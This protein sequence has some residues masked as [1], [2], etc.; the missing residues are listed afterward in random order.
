MWRDW[1]WRVGIVLGRKN[2]AATGVVLL[3]STKT[4]GKVVRRHRIPL[5]SKNLPVQTLS[6]F[7][8]KVHSLQ[9]VA[10][11]ILGFANQNAMNDDRCGSQRTLTTPR[12]LPHPRRYRLPHRSERP[13]AT[14]I[15]TEWASQV[16]GYASCR[17]LALV[18][19][20]ILKHQHATSR[21]GDHC[22]LPRA[23][24]GRP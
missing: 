18:V 8:I 7:Q 11:K 21:L 2:T 19:S 20:K 16:A 5:V 3:E 23:D 22:R 10:L 24:Q 9:H 14:M 15:H 13:D 17:R 1:R 6:S 4:T 12:Q